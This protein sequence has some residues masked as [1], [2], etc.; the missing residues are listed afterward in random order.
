MIHVNSSILYPVNSDASDVDIKPK[1]S[2]AHMMAEVEGSLI[3]QEGGEAQE[4][5]SGKSTPMVSFHDACGKC[6]KN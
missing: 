3:S 1:L 4:G 2:E 6:S 5:G